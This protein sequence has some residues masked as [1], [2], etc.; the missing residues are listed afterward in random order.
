[1]GLVRLFLALSV[2]ATHNGFILGGFFS[3]FFAVELFFAISGFC[4]ALV[5]NQKYT[6][7]SPVRFYVARY[8][9]LWPTYI[10]V[11]LIC[12]LIHPI[13]AVPGSGLAAN[14]Y[15]FASTL[16]LFGNESLWW[17]MSSSDGLIHVARNTDPNLAFRTS[18]PQMWSVGIE[19]SFYL[20]SPLFVRSWRTIAALMV[21]AF[22]LHAAF[23]LY[24]PD[25]AN[26]PFNRSQV[27]FFWIYLAGMLSYWMWVSV[28][29][30]LD[31]VGVP[32]LLISLIGIAAAGGFAVLRNVPAVSHRRLAIL[33]KISWWPF[34]PSTW[35]RYS[36]SR[37][38][39]KLT[40]QSAN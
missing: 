24:V 4:M 28:C 6:G 36:T 30:R 32:Q 34:S 23:V 38:H 17:F 3:G 19:L 29:E 5:L 14:L 26:S 39:Q 27:T 18:L 33:H 12:A 7:K 37:D 35:S 21:A 1:M 31:R 11:L 22:C 40:A 2:A 8:L 15:F 16:S 13:S 20:V 9:R 10:F 25:A